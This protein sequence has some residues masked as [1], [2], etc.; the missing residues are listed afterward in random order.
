MIALLGT[1]G[2]VGSRFRTYLNGQSMD[3]APVSRADL[4]IFDPI[5]LAKVLDGLSAHFVINCAG[6]TGKPNVDACEDHKLD[7]LMG[8]EVLRGVVAKAAKKL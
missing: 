1:S 2:D 8:N 6:Y 5:D 7:Y 3:Y 4:H